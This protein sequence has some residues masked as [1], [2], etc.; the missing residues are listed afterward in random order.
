MTKGIKAEIINNFNEAAVTY[1]EHA[2]IQ[3]Q[4]AIHLFAQMQMLKPKSILEIGCGTG[5]LTQLM[6]EHFSDSTYYISDIAGNMLERCRQ[7]QD[8]PT[9]NF[10]V[11]DGELL[12]ISKK[13]DLIASN[14]TFQWF[15][16]FETAL[17]NLSRQ[18]KTLAFS[19]LL[20][21]T[22]SGWRQ[23]HTE[24]GIK[25]N[26][27]AMQSIEQLEM[28]CKKFSNKGYDIITKT[29][30]VKFNNASEFI[31]SLRYIG[32]VATSCKYSPSCLKKL[33]KAFTQGITINYD[34]AHC[35]LQNS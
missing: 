33:L 5:F 7:K 34:V 31:K 11:A 35:V 14:L 30:T 6:Q 20:D 8:S 4:T 22:F 17:F 9:S 25:E 18:A 29:I 32:A 10:F 15:Q 1:D 2:A 16:D 28:L 26:A 13:L 24:L 3:K 19:T 21:G 23:K 27:L 12:P